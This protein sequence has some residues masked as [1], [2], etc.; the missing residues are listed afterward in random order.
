MGAKSNSPPIPYFPEGEGRRRKEG[1]KGKPNPS[2]SFSLPL[3]LSSP[4]NK[5]RGRHLGRTPSRI[6][7]TWGA[8]LAAPSSPHLYMSVF[9]ERGS[10]DL[11]ACGPRRG[12]A[13]GLYGP[14][15]SARHSRPS[16]GAKPHEADDTIPPQERPHQAGSRGAEI[17]A[18]Q[19]S[20][21]SHDVSHDDRDQAGTRR[22]PAR[23][24]SLFPL[25]C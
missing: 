1:R 21:G 15:S 12:C 7:P 8:L 2:P 19:T 25:W 3:F 14:S 16:R 10:P 6:R 17:K 20:R 18:R 24:M 23:A 22:A 4:A 9:W 5:E 11:P 13:A